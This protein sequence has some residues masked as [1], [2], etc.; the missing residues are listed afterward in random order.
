MATSSST[1]QP[2][3]WNHWN[4]WNRAQS[5]S[6]RRHSG[7]VSHRFGSDQSGCI[8]SDLF[9]SS[10]LFYLLIFSIDFSHFD[11]FFFLFVRDYRDY[12]DFDFQA[13]ALATKSFAEL[14]SKTI[15]ETRCQSCRPLRYADMPPL[16]PTCE[17]T[18]ECQSCQ[19][20]LETNGA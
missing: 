3:H 8:F 6:S 12:R 16:R 2:P 11:I 5:W 7:N 19:L 9:I 1:W 18:C 14:S 13:T 4:H 17:C 15:A 10:N 20:S